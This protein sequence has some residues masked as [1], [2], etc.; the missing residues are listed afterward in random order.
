M[1]ER[2]LKIRPDR[3]SVSL[4]YEQARERWR[5]GGGCT[6]RNDDRSHVGYEMLSP[7]FT[8]K[9]TTTTE[10]VVLGSLSDWLA[11]SF[12]FAPSAQSADEAG[13]EPLPARTGPE[14]GRT[15]QDKS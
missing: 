3:K 2:R 11:M 7:N 13:K 12:G 14:A 10:S 1:Q 8:P 15:G 6:W 5:G 9:S 4:I